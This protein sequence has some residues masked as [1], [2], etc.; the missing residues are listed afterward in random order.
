MFKDCLI[1]F[2]RYPES[3]KTKTRLIP[4]LGADGAAALHRKMAERMVQQAR[5][6][7]QTAIEVWYVGDSQELMQ[8]WLGA[9]LTYTEQPAGDLGD[10][11]CAA[12]RSG[13]ARGYAALM[14][15]G[16]DCPDV[17]T[18]VLAEGFVGLQNQVLTIGPA[19]DG[20]YYLI[21]LRRLVPELFEGIAWSTST[22][23]LETLKIVDR[24][25]LQ[26]MLLPCLRDIDVP[27]DLKYLAANYAEFIDFSHQK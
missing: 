16:T 5:L 18:A 6:L 2:T 21:G 24:L 23:L 4:A 3:G 13:F 14:I 22:V 7:P 26:V 10:R 12:F 9:D 11:M 8:N 25:Q 1:I 17:T 19:I 15:V 27:Q 20:G